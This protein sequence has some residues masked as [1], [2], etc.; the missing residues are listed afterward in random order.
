VRQ[1]GRIRRAP[2]PYAPSAGPF[3]GEDFDP[4]AW[5][6]EYPNP[7]FDNMQPADA[8]W[9][10]RRVAAF[11]DDALRAIVAKA[12]YSDPA[13]VEQIARALILRRD[14]IVRTWLVAVTPVVMPALEADGTLRFVNAAVDAGVAVPP[15]YYE[16]RWS[17]FDNTTDR[18]TSVGPPQRVAATG[19]MAPP[20]LLAGAAYVTVSVTASH[21]DHPH[22]AS[23]VNLYFRRSGDS[24][25][26]VGL[27]RDQGATHAEHE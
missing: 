2:R 26:P 6:A 19:G 10:A 23:P 8:F 7:A 11:S 27:F 21:P 20:G 12:Q 9:A 13:A 18:H 16:L 5:K 14:A 24:W 15:D 4:A 25:T 3:H 22:W 1:R 17:R